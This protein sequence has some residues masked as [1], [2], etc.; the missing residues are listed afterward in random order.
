MASNGARE[1]GRATSDAIPSHTNDTQ[2]A[3]NSSALVQPSTSAGN[4]SS[5]D[6][7]GASN[8]ST[9]RHKRK[10]LPLHGSGHSST[11]VGMVPGIFTGV[12]GSL[13]DKD[14]EFLCPICFEIYREAHMTKC[15][16][17]FCHECI[18][19]SMEQSPRCPKCNFQLETKEALF[20]NF[21]LDE[22]VAKYQRKM[23][24]DKLLSAGSPRKITKFA[25]MGITND[26]ARP[27]TEDLLNKFQRYKITNLGFTI[28]SLQEYLFNP[29]EFTPERNK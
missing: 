18:L 3:P 14:S 6:N 24:S 28:F 26:F 22:L 16:H 2:L 13:V 9:R 25:T 11:S 17:S 21:I 10:N 29:A 12:P 1:L 15:G 4:T 23:D 27:M 19:K 20:P 8:P 7:S 5:S